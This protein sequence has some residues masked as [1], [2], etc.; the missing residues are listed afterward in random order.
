MHEFH[1][2]SP[3]DRKAALEAKIASNAGIPLETI[4][5]AFSLEP[6]YDAPLAD[7][8]T[9]R[10]RKAYVESLKKT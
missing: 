6:D 3:E 7:D 10:Q 8:M 1:H 4:Q 9:Y 2:L 5:E